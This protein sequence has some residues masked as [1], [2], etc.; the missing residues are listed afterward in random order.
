[1][2]FLENLKF[3]LRFK[4]GGKIE[5]SY[6]RVWDVREDLELDTASASKNQSNVAMFQLLSS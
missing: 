3:H 4:I 6:Q 5:K 1:V 2:A